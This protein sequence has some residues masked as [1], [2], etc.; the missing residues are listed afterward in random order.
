M[1]NNYKF[2]PFNTYL[3]VCSQNQRRL[4]KIN[5]WA[6]KLKW[7]M[8]I[9]EPPAINV[10]VTFTFSFCFGVLY[11]LVIFEV[12]SWLLLCWEWQ[13][14]FLSVFGYTV[15]NWN[16]LHIISPYTF[17]HVQPQISTL[18]LHDQHSAVTVVVRQTCIWSKLICFGFIWPKRVLPIFVRLLFMFFGEV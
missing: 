6:I 16:D 14:P 18:L 7:K 3:F 4:R 11:K 9:K 1:L 17:A 12:C 13:S 8:H 10:N 2:W 15:K 5:I